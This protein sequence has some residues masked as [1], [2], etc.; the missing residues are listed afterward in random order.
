VEIDETT[1]LR[2]TLPPS[3][4]MFCVTTPEDVICTSSRPSL[5]I[6]A[7]GGGGGGGAGVP[8]VVDGT[9]VVVEPPT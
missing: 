6:T 8:E 2:P 3:T 4:I 1:S 7:G 9:L 5:V